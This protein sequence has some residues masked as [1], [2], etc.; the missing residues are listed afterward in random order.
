M[1][2]FNKKLIGGSIVLLLMINF[3][4]LLNLIYNLFM[5]RMLSL[6]SYGI[7]SALISIIVLFGFFTDTI[8]I[9]ISKYSAEET[10][11]G[12]IKNIVKKSFKKLFYGPIKGIKSGYLILILI[13]YL[14]I[15]IFLSSF[16]KINYSLFLLTA[17]MLV[18]ALC[19]PITRGTLQ[20]RKKFFLL[21]GSYMVDGLVKLGVALFLVFIGWDIYGAVG[22]VIAGS[23]AAFLVS[24]ISLK[25][26]LK[27]KEKPSVTPKIY[28]YTKPVSIVAFV[29]MV[30]LYIDIIIARH[31]FEPDLVGAYAIASTLA[32]IIFIG[33][34]PI[35]QAMFPISVESKDPKKRVNIFMNS[36][37]I[38]LLGIVVS[39]IVFLFFPNLVVLIYSGKIIIPS[40]SVLFYLGIAVSFI[41]IANLV[42][43]YKLSL[44]QTRGFAYLFI[45]ILL[46]IILLSYF[47]KSLIQFSWAFIT[48]SAMFLWA[49]ITI[50][51]E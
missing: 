29:V 12:K 30:F 24:L 17:L 14:I 7:L 40:I 44:G 10:D 51:K 2:I 32:K 8:Q 11:K 15:S 28:S 4:S 37:A 5:V 9:V 45:F 49:A 18:F 36:L 16:L 39:L 22:G 20:G 48:A 42:L 27:S 23:G 46:E 33:T 25:D 34:Y 19:I 38:L 3:F 26:I 1:K 31:F 43:I 13:S 47:S 41:A 35:S 6:A 21:G 50:I